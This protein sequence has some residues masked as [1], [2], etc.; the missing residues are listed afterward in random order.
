MSDVKQ[1]TSSCKLFIHLSLTFDGSRNCLNWRST[2][3]HGGTNIIILV[4][5]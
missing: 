5:S 4:A 2:S 1:G 3:E